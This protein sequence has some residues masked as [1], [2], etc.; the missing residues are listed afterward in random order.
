LERIEKGLGRKIAKWFEKRWREELKEVDVHGE[1]KFPGGVGASLG[2][3]VKKEV[4]EEAK[5]GLKQ[6]LWELD[7]RLKRR[8][9]IIVD[10]LQLTDDESLK[11]VCEIANVNWGNLRWILIHREKEKIKEKGLKDLS[12]WSLLDVEGMNEDDISALF[13]KYAEEKIVI[14][15]IDKKAFH[16]VM[17][18]YPNFIDTIV[19]ALKEK[20][21]EAEIEITEDFIRENYD[22]FAKP[23]EFVMDN[24]LGEDEKL[25]L[26]SIA[27]LKEEAMVGSIVHFLRLPIDTLKAF[28]EPLG[29]EPKYE[30]L[31]DF[32]FIE[33]KN[34][35]SDIIID[36][37]D[38]KKDRIVEVMKGKDK[39]QISRVRAQAITFYLAI[40]L[41]NAENYFITSIA[42]LHAYK[43]ASHIGRDT[44]LELLVNASRGLLDCG[45]N[46]FAY[47]CSNHVL[48][49][50]SKLMKRNDYLT[51]QKLRALC[52]KTGVLFNKGLCKYF[53]FDLDEIVEDV[54]KT[55]FSLENA[56][57][58]E[59]RKRGLEEYIWIL[60][61]IM[62][63]FANE[64]KADKILDLLKN[65]PLKKE[66]KAELSLIASRSLT[67]LFDERAKELLEEIKDVGDKYKF[68]I[69][70]IKGMWS[71]GDFEKASELFE[72]SAKCCEFDPSL[73]GLAVKYYSLAAVL[74]SERMRALEM[75]TNAEKNL[76]GAFES[77]LQYKFIDAIISLNREEKV[78]EFFNELQR[79]QLV[80]EEK[81]RYYWHYF[82][83]FTLLD[84]LEGLSLSEKVKK[85]I[86]N[87][88][89]YRIISPLNNREEALR[90][91]EES[92][93]APQDKNILRNIISSGDKDKMAKFVGFFFLTSVT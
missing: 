46:Y 29:V 42:Y 70:Y 66:Q 56:K 44:A 6:I 62:G 83:A 34:E 51:L 1:V 41:I 30:K 86:E 49:E 75:L 2:F 20:Y 79:M 89:L 90:M 15:R 23:M 4:K 74:T 87:S 58:E 71:L 84:C 26:L 17:N 13:L 19:S 54:T 59:I 27:L 47:I 60:S 68:M 45:D 28:L 61:G 33:I 77:I 12:G 50:I 7:S 9:V 63:Q 14:R 72:E 78:R 21:G 55:F 91:L 93:I 82:Q 43:H 24:Y 38:A 76:V 52:V 35:D 36:I 10:D 32:G 3:G 11:L 48:E 22:A 5:K 57:Q 92:E 16:G 65:S 39:E 18:G 73:K 80:K 67:S 85:V 53:E 69:P 64:G 25:N 81:I 40:A 8:T 37:H 88:P 31:K